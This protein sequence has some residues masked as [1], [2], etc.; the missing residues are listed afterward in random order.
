VLDG[1]LVSYLRI[2]GS[3]K[4]CFKHAYLNRSKTSKRAAPDVFDCVNYATAATVNQPANT[5]NQFQGSLSVF[6]VPDVLGLMAASAKSGLLR[7]SFPG[8]NLEIDLMFRQGRIGGVKGASVPRTSEA[9]LKLG[10]SFASVAAMVKTSSEALTGENMISQAD[11]ERALRLQLEVALLPVWQ[12]TVGHF[13]FKPLGFQPRVSGPSAVVNGLALDLT[14]RLDELARDVQAD[15]RTDQVFV[16]AD[17]IGDFSS[18][19]RQLM[20]DDW[21]VLSLLDGEST[22]LEIGTRA[23]MPWDALTRSIA[24]LEELGLIED[25]RGRREIARRYPKLDVGDT[26]PMFTLPALD[27]SAF[28]LGALR[29]KRTLLVFFRHAGCPFCNLH[30]HRLIEANDRLVRAGVQ[31]VGV[32]GSSVQGLQERVGLQ[33]PPFPLLADPDDAIHELYGT[34][35]SL[36]GLFAPGMLTTWLEGRKLGVPHGSTDGQ[37]TRMPADF[38][39]GPDLRVKY[40]HY[41]SN[42]AEHISLDAIER[43]ASQG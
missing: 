26:A 25:A 30:I 12:V 41:A 28:S 20:P 29:G 22:L 11:L 35:R 43:W 1:V 39:I 18:R 14:R 31:V 9:L 32:F 6:G 13:D 3:F 2:N 10:V 38:L 16:C 40:A 34:R 21:N 37:A 4:K 36:T 27:G 42:A 5:A 8:L 24:V 7:L 15:L 19:V 23:V 17:R 33:N